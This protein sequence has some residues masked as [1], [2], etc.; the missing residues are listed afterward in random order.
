MKPKFKIGDKIRIIDINYSCLPE[1][2]NNQI[3]Q[4]VDYFCGHLTNWFKINIPNEPLIWNIH[5]NDMKLDQSI[6][7]I[8]RNKYC[9]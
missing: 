9:K 5:I 4:I 6:F 8:V 3:G 2:F 7:Q 1:R